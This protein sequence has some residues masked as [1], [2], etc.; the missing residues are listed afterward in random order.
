MLIRDLICLL[1]LIIYQV[2]GTFHPV[3]MI[4]GDGGSQ[5]KELRFCHKL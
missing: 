2:D 4:P 3:I 5:V 1:C